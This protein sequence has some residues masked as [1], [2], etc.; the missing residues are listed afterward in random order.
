M[1]QLADERDDRHD[2]HED[3]IH[4]GGRAE[5]RDIKQRQIPWSLHVIQ[6]ADE[7]LS[8]VAPAAADGSRGEPPKRMPSGDKAP[9]EEACGPDSAHNR[10]NQEQP[11]SRQ[12]HQYDALETLRQALDGSSG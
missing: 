11:P 4:A 7:H 3:D 10:G 9:V 6:I 12:F 2:V 1:D 5:C 8:H